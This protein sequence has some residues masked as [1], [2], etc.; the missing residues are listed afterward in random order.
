M[1]D[2]RARVIL[3][4][5]EGTTSSVQYVYDVLFPYAR[6]ALPGFL[7]RD[8]SRADVVAAREQV[9]RDAG[10]P[11]FAVWLAM[12]S[13][14][15]PHG[16][17]VRHLHRL[18]SLDSKSTGL[19]ELQGLVWRDGYAAGALRSHV[20]AD[21]GPAME[22]W[23]K[24]GIDVRIY[25]SGS[26]EAQRVFFAHSEQGDLTRWLRGHYDTRIGPKQLAESYRA[27]A[28]D[29][30]IA[31]GEILFLS[32]I[33]GELDAARA[34]GMATGLVVRPGNKPVAAGHG[35]REV[36]SFDEVG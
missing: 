22:R 17:L 26:A 18:M 15:D 7:S 11:S 35:H 21:V 16:E 5:V 19:K 24:A 32:D 1:S 30:G 4:D 20:F 2:V 12:R 28:A 14:R 9:A 23:T 8:W 29:I 31:P 27:I 33:V 25:S 3:L 13:G 10:V 34:A 36:R 6:E